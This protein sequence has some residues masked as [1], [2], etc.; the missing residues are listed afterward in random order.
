M[1]ASS[2]SRPPPDA[3]RPLSPSALAAS[4]TTADGVPADAEAAA[5]LALDALIVEAGLILH[6]NPAGVA[7]AAALA[8]RYYARHSMTTSDRVA[9]AGGA[10]FLA[11]KL[12]ETPRTLAAV[13][14]ALRGAGLPPRPGGDPDDAGAADAVLTAERALLYDSGFRLGLDHP[15]RH[16]LPLLAAH[17]PPPPR[18]PSP[19]GKGEGDGG[20]AAASPPP[21]PHTLQQQ[22]WNLCVESVPTRLDVQV[23]ASAVAAGAFAVA[24]RLFG[25]TPRATA[26]APWWE[27][28]GVTPAALERV[29]DAL[30]GQYEGAVEGY[31]KRKEA[32]G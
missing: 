4:P 23:P 20:A 26:D 29:C 18:A 21:P 19:G 8:H 1:P 30:L 6:L 2:S 14:A 17:A 24:L 11:G 31:L 13:V 15:F 32:E 7:A 27:D 9:V 28:A 25:A 3:P 16:L 5:R 12:E 10:L 22:A